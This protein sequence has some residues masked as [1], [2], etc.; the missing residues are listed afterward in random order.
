VGQGVHHAG[1]GWVP[2][3]GGIE[4]VNALTRRR[5]TGWMTEVEV[6]AKAKDPKE[7]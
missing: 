3:V 6:E 5:W 4:R 1:E 7:K 2:Y